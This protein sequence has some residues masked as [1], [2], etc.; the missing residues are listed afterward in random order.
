MTLETEALL[1]ELQQRHGGELMRIEISHAAP[2]GRMRSWEAARPVVQWSREAKA[3]DRAFHRRRPRRARSPHLAR[4]RPDRVLPGLPLCR[5]A[6]ARGHARALPAGR[7]HRQHGAA[8]A[9]RDHRRDREGACRR[10]GCRAA[11]FRR[12]LGLVGDGRAAAPPARARHSLYGHARRA[13]LCRGGRGARSRADAARPCAIGGADAHLG[14]RQRDAGRRDACG[15]CRDR[16]GARDPSLGA[17]ARQGDRRTDAALWRR[18]SGRRGLARELA[19]PAHRARDARHAAILARR[20][21]R[22]HRADPGRPH[23]RRAISTR[24]A[25]TPPTTTAAIGRSAPARVFR[26]RS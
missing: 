8:V 15:I 7:A 13:V 26:R 19:R 17:C 9:R 2:L 11:A 16:R 10:P 5:L 4:P 18:L 3:H 21:A 24:A 22:A 20:G 1:S 12:S 23:A 14:P 25:S 6:G